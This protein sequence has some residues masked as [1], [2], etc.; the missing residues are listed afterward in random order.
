MKP[1]YA[2]DCDVCVFLGTYSTNAVDLYFCP[3]SKTLIARK[4][5]DGPDYVSGIAYVG[6]DGAITEAFARAY[7]KGLF[8]I[9]AL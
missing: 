1:L 3:A 7:R 8:E 4:S 2:H 5:S 9:T 6:T